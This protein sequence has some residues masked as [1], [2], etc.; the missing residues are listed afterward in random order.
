MAEPL[1]NH[2]GPEVV[3]ELAAQLQRVDESF[4]VDGF[5][6]MALEGFAELELTPRA[7]RIADAMA[8]FLPDDRGDALDVVVSAFGP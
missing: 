1:K 6:A 4:D 8:N 3:H 7:R 2:F 5:T